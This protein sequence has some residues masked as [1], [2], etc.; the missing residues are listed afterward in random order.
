MSASGT[1]RQTITETRERGLSA[2]PR[3]APGP[4]AGAPRRL[5]LG[6][7]EPS[8]APSLPAQERWGGRRGPRR[9]EAAYPR[10][11]W[12]ASSA[13]TA[14]APV[15]L[16][17]RSLATSL[18]P[19][20][21]SLWPAWFTGT[22][23]GRTGVAAGS[24]RTATAAAGLRT[25]HIRGINLPRDWRARRHV[26][27]APAAGRAPAAA[28][29]AQTRSAVPAAVRVAGEWRFVPSWL[30]FTFVDPKS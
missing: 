10:P 21:P 19:G 18:V 14:G 1:T 29:P 9:E 5:R 17:R 3:A 24:G 8:S 20:N 12:S 26:L 11:A 30:L 28:P 22:F 25:R 7:A 23:T 4:P 27:L 6:S 13:P 16:R 2:Q 15:A